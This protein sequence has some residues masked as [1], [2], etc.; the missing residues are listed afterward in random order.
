MEFCVIFVCYVISIS[1]KVKF[2]VTGVCSSFMHIMGL[3]E[4]QRKLVMDGNTNAFER[5]ES[6]GAS[7]CGYVD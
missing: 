5:G 2:S 7:L 3:L 4:V 6:E 1:I